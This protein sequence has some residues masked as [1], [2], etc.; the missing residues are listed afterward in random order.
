MKKILYACI[1]L[2]FFACKKNV[3]SVN[4][5]DNLHNAYSKKR[6]A[7]TVEEVKIVNDIK[8]ITPILKELYKNKNVL[9]EINSAIQ[10]G[11]YVEEQ[12]KLS[13]LLYPDNS[14]LYKSKTVKNKGL[15]STEYR[16]LFDK[17]YGS[18]SQINNNSLTGNGNGLDGYLENFN[19]GIYFPY[20]ENFIQVEINQVTLTPTQYE[21]DFGEGFIFDH[22]TNNFT[23]VVVNDF[24]AYS[25]PVHIITFLDNVA[26]SNNTQ[27]NPSLLTTPPQTN[28]Q[29]LR[30]FHGFGR[31]TR[32]L[33]PLIGFI[34]SGGSEMVVGRI[35]GYLE[36][37]DGHVKDFKG[38]LARLHYTRK[39]IKEHRW[40]RTYS[41]WDPHWRVDDKEQAYCAYEEDNSGSTKFS[42]KIK[43]KLAS[44]VEGEIGFEVTVKT[45]DGLQAQV[46]QNR[47]DYLTTAR[48]DQ[49]H[50]FLSNPADN[51]FLT[52]G[53][54]PIYNGGSSTNWSWTWPYNWY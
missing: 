37:V 29:L 15:F 41:I 26:I 52:S 33:D 34:N 23:Q 7:R 21:A 50:G 31:L 43:T 24:Y 32:Q 4:Q 53:F 48:Q 35:S 16:R 36:R 27:Q 20:S 10:S 17:M 9:D 54:W 12:V 38:D 28:P 6:E 14:N 46:K 47:N 13:D 40:V 39:A 22:N 44:G 25:N 18:P 19:L 3:E 45:E 8:K 42:G 1:S 51:T 11:Y 5:L 30:V 2:L 49:G